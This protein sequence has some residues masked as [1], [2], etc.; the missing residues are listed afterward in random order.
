[1]T[2]LL[3]VGSTLA[4]VGEPLPDIEMLT[5]ATDNCGQPAIRRGQRLTALTGAAPGLCVRD[6][7]AA[8]LESDEGVNVV[9]LVDMAKTAQPG[10]PQRLFIYRLRGDTL[11]PRMLGSGPR[12]QR[13]MGARRYP[14]PVGD[15]LL[16]E[17][18]SR[19]GRRQ[20]LRCFF[21][22]FPLL[23]EPQGYEVGP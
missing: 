9:L 5:T 7:F 18:V 4:L 6:G 17:V 16:V 15:Q 3:I 1:M 2:V 10:A 22:G 8:R 21:R 11:E 23:C 12:S 13:L 19:G 20:T 14:G